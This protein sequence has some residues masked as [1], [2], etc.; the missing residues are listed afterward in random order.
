MED[1]PSTDDSTPSDEEEEKGPRT[2]VA[3]SD[4]ICHECLDGLN[5]YEKK[6]VVNEWP[7]IRNT[8]DCDRCAHAKCDECKEQ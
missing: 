4:W 8:P 1:R 6:E 3:G 5:G 7:D 2:P